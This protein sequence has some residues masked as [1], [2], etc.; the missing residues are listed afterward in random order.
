MQLTN[1]TLSAG[2]RTSGNTVCRV[3]GG[4]RMRMGWFGSENSAMAMRSFDGRAVDHEH[5]QQASDYP[6]NRG[7]PAETILMR[8]SGYHSE[9]CATFRAAMLDVPRQRVNAGPGS[10]STS[11]SVRFRKILSRLG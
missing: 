3:V 6:R 1:E 10:F 8:L 4:N 7:V 5:E 11:L 9:P 2:E